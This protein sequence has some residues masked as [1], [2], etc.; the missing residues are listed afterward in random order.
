MRTVFATILVS[1]FFEAD[2]FTAEAGMPQLDPKYWASQAFWLV[3]VFLFLY[4]LSSRIFIPKIKNSLDNRDRKIK[5][6]LDE[7]KNS[8]NLSEKKL[9]EYETLVE[10]AKKEVQKIL[11]DS[12]NKL[13]QD[14]QNKKKSFEVEIDKETE[15]AQKEIIQL[16]KDS[17][18]NITKISEDIAANIIEELSGDKLNES[19]IKAAVSEVSKNNLS[20]YL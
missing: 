8:K 20:K 13:N 6:D 2:L 5:D 1:V 3:I 12:K 16:K 14:I 18:K 19:S 9:K 10:N 15:K 4:I 7:A 11:Q 17:I